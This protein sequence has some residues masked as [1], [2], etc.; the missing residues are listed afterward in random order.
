MKILIETSYNKKYNGCNFKNSSIMKNFILNS[1]YVIKEVNDKFISF[2]DNDGI[3]QTIKENEWLIVLN[4]NPTE[5]YIL[6]TNEFLNMF[7]I[8]GVV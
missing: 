6:S 3:I 2:Y 4:N 7:F 8:N 5:Y 1:F